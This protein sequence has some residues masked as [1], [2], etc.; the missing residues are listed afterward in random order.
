MLE[1]RYR[2]AF[3]SDV[4]SLGIGTE[5]REWELEESDTG[6]NENWKRAALGR[7]GIG[8]ER[9]WGEWELEE[10]GTGESGNWKR[11]ALI[12]ERVGKNI[13]KSEKSRKYAKI[14]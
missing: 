3:I 1:G 14:I 5:L 13:M 4:R 12:R 9:H 11:A 10:S 8:R 2:N 6:E 7:V